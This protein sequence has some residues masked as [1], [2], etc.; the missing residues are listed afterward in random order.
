MLF[1]AEFDNSTGSV[2]FGS[3]GALTQLLPNATQEILGLIS[4][5]DFPYG[6][7]IGGCRTYGDNLYRQNFLASLS[8]FDICPFTEAGITYPTNLQFEDN[9]I[10]EFR[11]QVPDWILDKAGP[12]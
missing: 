10:I 12:R 11:E 9:A 3:G 4:L 2:D 7:S 5:A 6:G 8:F 1:N